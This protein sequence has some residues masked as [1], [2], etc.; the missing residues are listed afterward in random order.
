MYTYVYTFQ[1]LK[2]HYSTHHCGSV[3]DLS[4][5]VCA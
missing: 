4:V 1:I 5:K 3:L 2:L